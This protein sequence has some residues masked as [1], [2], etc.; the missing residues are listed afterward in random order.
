M[1]GCFVRGRE[2]QNTL[3][4]TFDTLQ[5]SWL[6]VMVVVGALPEKLDE[7]TF[8]VHIIRTHFKI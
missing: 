8:K 2:V 7:T 4:S 5:V 3:V 1:G 6:F